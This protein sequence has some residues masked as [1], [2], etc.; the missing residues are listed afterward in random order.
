MASSYDVKETTKGDSSV[1]TQDDKGYLTFTAQRSFTIVLDVA[2]SS[3]DSVSVRQACQSQGLLPIEGQSHPNSSILFCES[4]DVKRD[5]PI[6]YLAVAKYKSDKIDPSS[7]DED[8]EPIDFTTKISWKVSKTNEPVDEDYNGAALLN[9]GTNEPIKG[10]TRKVA[11]IVAVLEKNFVAFN[12]VAIRQ[13]LFTT[14]SDTFLGFP[15]GEGF[16]E[17]IV[18]D[19]VIQNE[20]TY[21]RVRA[22]VHFRTPYRTTSEKAWYKRVIHEGYKEL[23]FGN[24]VDEVVPADNGHGGDT[25]TPVLLAENGERLED[26]ADPHWQEWQL[27]GQTT[28]SDMGFDDPFV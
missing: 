24:F 19:P 6:Y 20:F 5:S 2:E 22:E 25:T 4:V 11:D 15:P 17:D 13:Y 12:P 3:D 26:G 16:V 23:I 14:N 1:T 28:F 7:D 21:H 27:Y 8:G 9:S 10:L 18:A